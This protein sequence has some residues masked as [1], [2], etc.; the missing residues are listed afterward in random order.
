MSSRTQPARSNAQRGLQ[1]AVTEIL[2][3]ETG[4]EFDGVNKPLMT[5]RRASCWGYDDMQTVQRQCSG[6]DTDPRIGED[7]RQRH[8]SWDALEARDEQSVLGGS[9]QPWCVRFRC[10]GGCTRWPCHGTREVTAFGLIRL[11][12]APPADGGRMLSVMEFR[13]CCWHANQEKKTSTFF[14]FIFY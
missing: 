14:F 3:E 9:L 6:W 10:S 5:L 8:A 1:A 2:Q 4:L 7:Q 11:S 12:K 13:T